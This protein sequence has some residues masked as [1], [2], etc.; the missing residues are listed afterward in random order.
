MQWFA[1]SLLNGRLPFLKPAE[2]PVI[3]ET[4][5]DDLYLT[6]AT[7]S[8]ERVK[9]STITLYQKVEVFGETWNLVTVKLKAGL[10]KVP[11]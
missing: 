2:T 10:H 8:V 1:L 7:S 9:N 3:A 4:D 6:F 11:D 5:E